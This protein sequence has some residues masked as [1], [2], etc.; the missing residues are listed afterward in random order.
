MST[1]INNA[2]LYTIREARVLL[3]IGNTMIWKLIGRGDLECLKLGSRALIPGR[4]IA[5]LIDGLPRHQ[6]K[7]TL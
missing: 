7:S 5:A 3:S 2:K 6:P 1:E 4:S